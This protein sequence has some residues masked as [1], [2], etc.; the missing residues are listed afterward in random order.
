M[1]TTTTTTPPPTTTTPPPPPTTTTT[2]TQ[3]PTTTQ[4]PT[5]TTT[6]TTPP[7]TTTTIAPTTNLPIVVNPQMMPV[8][9]FTV[10]MKWMDVRSVHISHT[11]KHN[12]PGC[13]RVETVD[14]V[15]L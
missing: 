15:R 9:T 1:G 7:P 11:I 14:G 5:T 4:A 6:T 12:P 8:V 2:T 10:G 3:P 13:R